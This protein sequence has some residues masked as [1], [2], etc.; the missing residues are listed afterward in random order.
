MQEYPGLNVLR[1]EHVGTT[2]T[3]PASESTIPRKGESEMSTAPVDA[4]SVILILADPLAAIDAL[5]V[6]MAREVFRIVALTDDG[7]DALDFAVG[8]RLSATQAEQD[9][10]RIG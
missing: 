6:P 2:V 7:R 1:S 10:A 4:I 8:D 3:R 9:G 5:L